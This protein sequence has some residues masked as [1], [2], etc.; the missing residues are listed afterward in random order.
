MTYLVLAVLCLALGFAGAWWVLAPRKQ[1][2][3]GVGRRSH[4]L[5]ELAE[6]D[7]ENVV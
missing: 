2:L 4:V 1:L 5:Y 3:E 6:G 7:L